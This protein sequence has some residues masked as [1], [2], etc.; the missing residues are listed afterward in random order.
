MAP[1]QVRMRILASLSSLLLSHDRSIRVNTPGT[2]LTLV[3]GLLS[4]LSSLAFLS[5]DSPEIA[6]VKDLISKVQSGACAEMI[7]ET[8][9][10][11]YKVAPSEDKNE[12]TLTIQALLVT[13][14]AR[15]LEHGAESSRRW[16]L[17]Y[18]TEVCSF[19][20]DYGLILIIYYRNTGQNHRYRLHLC[21]WSFISVKSAYSAAGS[22][23]SCFQ[24][25]EIPKLRDSIWKSPFVFSALGWSL[26]SKP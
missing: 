6:L 18:S 17:R 16:V 11:E 1:Q 24:K 25:R 20:Y 5:A 4:L 10:R 19:F 15:F 14:I 8:L 13:G 2:L 3:Q 12:Q 26:K 23:I 22:L 21:S 7:P 9:T